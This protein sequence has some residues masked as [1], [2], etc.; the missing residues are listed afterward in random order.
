MFIKNNLLKIKKF[1]LAKSESQKAIAHTS[2]VKVSA[3]FFC[4]I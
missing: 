2:L 1:K 3:E 4:D